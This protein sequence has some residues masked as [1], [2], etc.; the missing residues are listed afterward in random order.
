MR[1]ITLIALLAL[2]MTACTVTPDDPPAPPGPP[3]N[4]ILAPERDTGQWVTTVHGVTVT[5]RATAPGTA[6]RDNHDPKL[7]F[8]GW[9]SSAVGSKTCVVD[10]D[11][12]NARR[13]QARIA[14]HEYGHCAQATYNLPGI[15]RADLGSY[16]AAPGEGYAET[17]AQAYLEACGN[18]L[19]PLGFQ[20][21]AVPTCAEAPDP[22]TVT[23]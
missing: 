12:V 11:L 1:K 23:P 20:D 18:S 8:V 14:A 5:W 3:V 9:A 13:E 4:V 7:F 21:F 6:N 10:I 15:P 22:R 2:L 16:Y 17:Y 19:K